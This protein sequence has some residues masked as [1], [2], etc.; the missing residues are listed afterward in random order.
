MIKKFTIPLL[1]IGVGL[2]FY[3]FAKK[4]R[5]FIA[6]ET[7]KSL[8]EIY[9]KVDK[10]NLDIGEDDIK[11][12]LA[13]L[14][15]EDLLEINSNITILNNSKKNFDVIS[16]DPNSLQSYN[17]ILGLSRRILSKVKLDYILKNY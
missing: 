15:I 8:S 4:K 16:K 5:L 9:E 6:Q 2:T 3:Y 13:E 10:K 7:E 12:K 17:D 1:V 14:P 11:S